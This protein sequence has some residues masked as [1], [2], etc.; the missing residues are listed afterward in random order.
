MRTSTIKI[1]KNKTLFKVLFQ[2]LLYEFEC[3]S[4][5]LSSCWNNILSGTCN[6]EWKEYIKTF[7]SQLSLWRMSI[8]AN[9][10]NYV[11]IRIKR[12][13]TWLFFYSHIVAKK[14][15]ST[16][17]DEHCQKVIQQKLW[18][19]LNHTRQHLKAYQEAYKRHTS[20]I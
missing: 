3:I 17:T 15:K 13:S 12:D 4:I 16:L 5:F 6:L 7:D 11:K 9:Q 19:H 20:L 10:K 14:L 18:A 8:E 2:H 1:N